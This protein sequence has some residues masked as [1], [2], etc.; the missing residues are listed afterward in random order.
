MGN[1]KFTSLVG[2]MHY[3]LFFLFNSY[4]EAQNIIKKKQFIMCYSNI[5][6]FCTSIL[7]KMVNSGVAITMQKQLLDYGDKTKVAIL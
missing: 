2:K 4:S 1:V 5:L 6:S 3:Q 7:K